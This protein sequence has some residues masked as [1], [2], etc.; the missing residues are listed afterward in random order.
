MRILNFIFLLL[1]S[2][3]LPAY[4]L[5]PIK[6]KG[7]NAGM[8][9]NESLNTLKMRGY[10]CYE[11]EFLNNYNCSKD[12][13]V[14]ISF[15]IKDNKL[16]RIY[17][18][19]RSFG[20]VGKNTMEISQAIQSNFE[21]GEPYIGYIGGFDDNNTHFWKFS[22]NSVLVINTKNIVHAEEPWL[23]YWHNFRMNEFDKIIQIYEE[24][25]K[26]LNFD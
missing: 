17:Y 1:V 4:A 23:A 25:N 14:E 21:I 12:E 8:D 7:I 3:S 15:D 26:N 13:N 9:L 5:D 20:G 16:W 2:I 10:N 18:E 6:I 22:N 19:A 11:S 24:K